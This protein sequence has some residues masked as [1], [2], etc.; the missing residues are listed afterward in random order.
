MKRWRGRR[1]A[2]TAALALSLTA[3]ACT[4]LGVA[5]GVAWLKRA[6]LQ[7]L[8]ELDGECRLPGLSAPVTV[9][10][11]WHGVPHIQAANLDDLAEA[12]GFVVAQDRLWQLDMA[13]R[14]A[15]GDLAEVLGPRAVAHDRIQRVLEIRAAAERLTATMPA[16][17]KRI[18]EDY[19]RGVNAY[20]AS[21]GRRL[22][23][24]FRLLH[25]KPKPWTPEDCWLVSLNMVEMLDSSVST[26]LEREKVQALLPPELAMQLYPT[27]TWRD[28]PPTQPIPPLTDPPQ[29]VPPQAAVASQP[30][31]AGSVADLLALRRALSFDE[32]P[33]PERPGSNEWAVSGAHTA[34][35]R[36]LLS[37][38]MHL[39]HS[40]PDVWHEEDLA[41][42]SF[43]AAGVALPGIPL[44]VA[45]HN[46]HIAWGFTTLNGDVQDVYVEKTN[47]AGEY[48]SG[49][50]WRRPEHH[51]ER[52][53]VR[54]GRDV[55]L[56]L[57]TTVHGPVL[58]PLLPGER[59]ML[60]LR[61]TLYDPKNTDW[62]L[63]ALDEA[64]DWT[65]FRAAMSRWW[66]PT[67]NVV[68]A[69]DQ[70]HIGYQAVGDF[71]IRPAG[72]SPVPI[73][74]TG[75]A[76]DS[77]HEWQ[78]S[79]PFAELPSILDPA[80]GIV[81]TANSRITPDAYPYSLA[82]NWAEPYRNERI[83]KWLAG[84]QKLT[85]PQMLA[86][87]TD[88]FSEIDRELAERFAYA[89]DRTSGASA[90][91]RQAADTLR[92]WNGVITPGSVAAQ[93]V[94]SAKDAFWP[95]LLQP[96]LG[97][98][99][100]LYSW[101][102]K[103]FVQETMVE[104]L[105]AEWL[106]KNYSNWNDFLAA[107]VERG[108]RDGRAP[109][110][111]AGWTFGSRHPLDIEHPLYGQLPFFRGWT[112]S[113]SYPLTGDETTVDQARGLLGPSQRFTMDWSDVDASTENIVMGESGDPL[114]P[115]YRDQWPDWCG[116][117][118]FAL[119]FTGGAVLASTRH[120]LRLAP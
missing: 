22:P 116:G 28:R 38:D 51:R 21:H 105:P 47:G 50:Q 71:P 8:P 75:T 81:A 74:E 103:D 115:Y 79:V 119:A 99:W 33:S 39:Q 10:R 87:Q 18:F 67:Q 78:G 45:G 120:T 77:R 73:L 109:R 34:S 2:L 37:N 23:A 19:S 69:D 11:D 86:L 88:T 66:G 97:Q 24:E 61:W 117:R 62:P 80:S 44:I 46:A 101:Q 55:L 57:E 64:Q 113:G 114:S 94:D 89:I 54:G 12:Q 1:A 93:I 52:I 56:D 26:K 13:R 63:L 4:G 84:K 98:A 70:G 20:I 104:S 112:G 15:A 102:D 29:N 65:A 17:Q 76:E 107:C 72:P 14:F 90:R 35:G 92:V 16:D 60:A 58:N 118:S 41:A 42:G 110:S 59:R 53:R 25:Y 85:A 100:R 3:A 5:W 106:P 31:A 27:T 48:W 40:I 108:M 9:R 82:L 95:L 91:L 83:W 6:M 111:L 49:G 32:N 43:H 7:Q 96:K 36:P 30:T 68:Y